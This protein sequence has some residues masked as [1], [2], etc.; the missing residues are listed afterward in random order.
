MGITEAITVFSIV[1][2]NWIA[3]FYIINKKNKQ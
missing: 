1:A 3:V 2:I